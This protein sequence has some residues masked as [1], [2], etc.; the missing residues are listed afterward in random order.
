MSTI[1]K[2]L[3]LALLLSPI[4]FFAFRQKKWYLYLFCGLVCFLP[5]QFAVEVHS[6]LPLISA[7]RLLTL[8]VVIFWL[9]KCYKEKKLALPVSIVAFLAVNLVVSFINLQNG[10]SEINRVFLFVFERVLV[11]LAVAGLVED[12][13]EF[14]RCVDFLILGCM[15]VSVI[16]LVQMAFSFDISSVLHLVATVSSSKVPDRMG[17]ERAFGTFNAI[18]F[19]CYCVIMMLLIY[20]RLESTKK[21]RYS[22]AFAVTFLTM[23][24]TLT[25]SAWLCFGVLFVALI[26]LHKG[27]P[28]LRLLPSAGFAIVLCLALCV[29]QPKLLSAIVETGK[30]TLNTVMSALPVSLRPQQKIDATTPSNTPTVD[31][32]DTSNTEPTT[33]PTAPTTTKP[34]TPYFELDKDFGMNANAPINSRTQQWSA[35][36]RM[37]EDGYLLFGYGYNAFVDG[38]VFYRP[39]TDSAWRKAHAVDVGLVTLGTECGLIGFLS[40]FALLGYMFVVSWLRRTRSKEFD[41]Y[42]MMLYFIPLYLILNI[43]SSFLHKP[44]IWMVFALFY[45]YH[46]LE[47]YPC[48]KIRTYPA[49]KTTVTTKTS[50]Q[51]EAPA[52]S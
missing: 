6:K 43:A 18:A 4:F 22:V 29:A 16:G 26:L 48:D 50:T 8:L 27:K 44:I 5:E 52:E 25:R 20:Y 9:V 14:D 33:E 38:K 35:L 37:V 39:N 23:F 31:T 19:G 3:L 36:E 47:G 34:D 42:K 32:P 7:S 24:C 41:Y 1:L 45:A 11:V 46:K 21:Q 51:E 17:L 28:I 40:M 13:T 30:S 10:F 12:R 2:W 49:E 15:A